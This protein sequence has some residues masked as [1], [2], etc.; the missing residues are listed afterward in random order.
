MRI[1]KKWFW[2]SKCLKYRMQRTWMIATVL[3]ILTR[4]IFRVKYVACCALVESST[5]L[6]YFTNQCNLSRKIKNKSSID[7]QH[8]LAPKESSGQIFGQ[9][10]AISRECTLDWS[11]GIASYKQQRILRFHDPFIFYCHSTTLIPAIIILRDWPS[12][13]FSELNSK[14]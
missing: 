14:W 2:R 11:D 7:I 3:V 8:Q 13:Q 6:D 10:V 5:F 12:Q 9:A 4:V 1:R